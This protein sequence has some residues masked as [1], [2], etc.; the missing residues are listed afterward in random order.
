[1]IELPIEKE[2]DRC[3]VCRQEAK[4]ERTVRVRDSAIYV[5]KPDYVIKKICSSCDRVACAI[6]GERIAS[7]LARGFIGTR[8]SEKRYT[9]YG[10]EPEPWAALPRLDR[11]P[12]KKLL[13]YCPTC[14]T[15]YGEAGLVSVVNEKYL[16][17]HKASHDDDWYDDE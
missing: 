9:P 17:A 10:I 2:I 8:R 4:I 5:F 11:S 7:T 6:C 16:K 15:K 12:D 13:Y 1:M 3:N 14:V